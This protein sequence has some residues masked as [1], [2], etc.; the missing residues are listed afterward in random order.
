ML[1]H[2]NAFLSRLLARLRRVLRTHPVSQS[3]S[4]SVGMLYNPFVS[5]PDFIERP[6]VMKWPITIPSRGRGRL[7]EPDVSRTSRQGVSISD[8]NLTVKKVMLNLQMFGPETTK[9]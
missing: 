1:S 3:V 5:L 7:R 9:F 6:A 4:Q 2:Q 8:A